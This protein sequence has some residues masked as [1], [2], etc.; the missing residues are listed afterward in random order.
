MEKKMGTRLNYYGTMMILPSL[1]I[2][3]FL[4]VYADPASVREQFLL[5]MISNF[6]IGLLILGLGLFILAWASRA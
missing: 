5:S 4:A 3:F 6:M 2:L 1:A